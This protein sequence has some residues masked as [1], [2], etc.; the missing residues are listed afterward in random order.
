[1]AYLT[2]CICGKLLS[3]LR[4]ACHAVGCEAPPVGHPAIKRAM[5]A[6][7]KRGMYE[8]RCKHFID[9]CSYP[10]GL[11]RVPT[12]PNT[13]ICEVARHEACESCQQPARD[14][15]RMVYGDAMARVIH[16]FAASAIR[17]EQ[18]RVNCS[19]S[20]RVPPLPGVAHV[21]RI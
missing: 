3:Y 16:I 5:I 12:E 9:R 1:M 18:P 21:R 8:A 19:R 11:G 10:H 20:F 2:L 4:A 17:S 14:G 6:I 7:V 15:L 13:H